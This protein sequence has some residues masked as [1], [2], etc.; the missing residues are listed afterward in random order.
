MARPPRL[1]IFNGFHYIICYLNFNLSKMTLLNPA[2]VFVGLGFDVDLDGD[3]CCGNGYD[4]RGGGGVEAGVDGLY[5]AFA[6]AYAGHAFRLG[7]GDGEDLAV[8]KSGHLI[9]EAGGVRLGL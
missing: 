2:F 3:V 9:F 8:E 1:N 4:D 5:A 7:K 6:Q